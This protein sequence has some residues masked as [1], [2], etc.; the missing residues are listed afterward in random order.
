M[1]EKRQAVIAVA[2][3]PFVIKL[4]CFVAVT[5][6]AGD[7]NYLRHGL[8]LIPSYFAEG[9]L[10]AQL[11]RMAV[12]G[13]S[14]P[15]AFSGDKEADLKHFMRRKRTILSS[16]II[17][18][19]IK[20][21]LAFL[22]GYMLDA[23][24]GVIGGL[25]QAAGPAAP[26]DEPSALMFLIGVGALATMIWALRLAY[27][28]VPAAMGIDLVDFLARVKP[29]MFSLRLLGT[30]L[31][32]FVPVAMALVMASSILVTIF[33]GVEGTPSVAFTYGLTAVQAVLE[34]VAAALSSVAVAYGIKSIYDTGNRP[35]HYL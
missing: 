32:C 20:L 3:V 7:G 8:Y 21:V 31:L 2:L 10:M 6:F 35:P 4:L 9:W 15:I 30:W 23:Q 27:L 5:A 25:E 13:E 22:S 26:G 33:P 17:Y 24:G 18:V 16:T 19:L 12:F 14:W 28:Y 29:Y 34:I 11:I 1:W